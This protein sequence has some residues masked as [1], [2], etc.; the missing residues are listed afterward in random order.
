[1]GEQRVASIQSNLKWALLLVAAASP[2]FFLIPITHDAAWQMW[3]GRQMA[4]GANLYTD[5][6]EVNPPLWFWMAEPLARVAEALEVRSLAIL[7]GFF[8]LSMMLSTWLAAR[9]ARKGVPIWPMAVAMLFPI[10]HFAQREHFILIFTIPYVLL[11]A[12]REQ[13]EAVPTADAVAIG[14]CAG[15]AFAL[16]PQFALV[17][18]ILE[19]WAWRARKIR[20]ETLTLAASAAAYILAVAVIEPDYRTNMVPLV[21]A[22]YAQFA[23]MQIG[24]VKASLIAFLFGS[25]LLLRARGEAAAF[26]VAA[27]AAWLVYLLQ[28]KG[29]D[30]QALPA[31]GLLLVAVAL[32]ADGSIVRRALMAGAAIVIVVPSLRPYRT[33]PEFRLDVRPGSSFAAL[34][35]APRAGWPLVEERRLKWP[36]PYMSLWMAPAVRPDVAREL[37]CNPPDLLLIDDRQVD[38]S[39]YAGPVLP[40]YSMVSDGPIKL[41]RRVGTPAKPQGCRAVY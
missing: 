32:A 27:L 30:Y 40:A 17:P 4:H 26:T 22:A 6:V 14:F 5:I 21:M 10:T 28:M 13:G 36:L 37:A 39:S 33:P 3:T 24:A 25:P 38:F 9:V 35:I 41:L 19:L 2:I 34:S 8:I 15:V 29:W 7:I 16:K 31:V 1:M 23:P 11:I 20:P 12:R 18:I